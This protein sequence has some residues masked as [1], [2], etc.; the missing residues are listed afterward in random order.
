MSESKKTG[1]FLQRNERQ[2]EVGDR[3]VTCNQTIGTVVRVDC[4]NNG[5]FIVVRLDVLPREF[6]Y[7]PCDLKLI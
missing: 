1:S 7:D 5:V 6:A 2:F 4:D 3:V